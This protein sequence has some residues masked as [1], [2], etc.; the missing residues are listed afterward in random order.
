MSAALKHLSGLQ[1]GSYFYAE[2]AEDD[3]LHERLLVGVSHDKKRLYIYTRDGDLYEEDPANYSV[4]HVP[5][6]R[7][8]LPSSAAA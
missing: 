5:G 4:V 7:G 8:G 2:Y 6:P 3:Y 1:V